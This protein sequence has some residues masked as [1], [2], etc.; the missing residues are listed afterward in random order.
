MC[1]FQKE[2][3]SKIQEK[4]ALEFPTDSKF[5]MV[6]PSKSNEG[7]GKHVGLPWEGPSDAMEELE[8]DSDRPV[9]NTHNL[10]EGSSE[11]WCH[12]GGESVGIVCLHGF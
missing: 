7:Q 8:E 10:T 3:N 9:G 2:I 1:Q 6:C 5:P 12:C 11:H 4:K